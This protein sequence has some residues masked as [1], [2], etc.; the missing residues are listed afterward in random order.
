M[1]LLEADHSTVATAHSC[2]LLVLM[3]IYDHKIASDEYFTVFDAML[4]RQWNQIDSPVHSL[5]F[6]CD[7][8]YEALQFYVEDMHPCRIIDII[9]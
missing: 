9:H 4:L 3:H 1:G 7:S 6:K 5:A 8:M 2:A